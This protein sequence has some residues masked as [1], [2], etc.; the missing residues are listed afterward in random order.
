M[1]LAPMRGSWPC[2]AS[3][4]RTFSLT[5]SPTFFSNNCVSS[6]MINLSTTSRIVSSSRGAKGMVASRRLRNSGEKIRLIA[7]VSSPL[8]CGG[9]KPMLARCISNA[10][11][12]LVMIRITCRKSV[13]RPVLSVSFPWSM[14]CRRILNRSGCAFSISSRSRTACGCLLTAS[15]SSP[16]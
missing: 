13:E 11:A 10:P 6:S 12:L 16:P 14:I 4:W 2:P 15:V 1:G 3:H 8:L 7:S 9:L 5:S